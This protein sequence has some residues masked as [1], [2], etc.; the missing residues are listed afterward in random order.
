MA[1]GWWAE[2]ITQ[3]AGGAE[4]EATGSTPTIGITQH[5]FVQGAAAGLT[6]TGSVPRLATALRP[7][8]GTPSIS[9]GTPQIRTGKI[10]DP[11]GASLAISGGIPVPGTGLRPTGAS[12]TASGSTAGVR[13]DTPLILVGQNTSLT[14]SVTIPA[15]QVG[16]LI[17]IYAWHD[18]LSF[19]PN[20]PGK[21]TASGTVP[22][23]VDIDANVG[24]DFNASR[25]AYFVAT[26][27]DHTSGT[28]TNGVNR[29]MC[30][31]VIRNPNASPIGG[32]AESG[33]T[34]TN[35]GT[36]PSVTMT[37]TV[38]TSMLLHFFARRSTTLMTSWSTPPAGYTSRA[39]QVSINR[40]ISFITKDDTQTDGQVTRASNGSLSTGYRGATVEILA[41]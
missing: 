35:G 25:T 8:G 4:L 18:G 1:T 7:T 29:A 20:P 36:A 38:G 15:H 37:D 13:I 24:A 3:P 31:V 28:W 6:I 26:A 22:A 16:D 21:P 10:V 9:G 27:T 41:L 39:S 5:K 12:L 32:H 19:N 40:G 23:W 30:A 33:S 14:N 34:S 11:T 2:V 17:V